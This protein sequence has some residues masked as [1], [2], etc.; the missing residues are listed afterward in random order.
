MG[1]DGEVL[2]QLATW[3][4]EAMYMLDSLREKKEKQVRKAERELAETHDGKCYAEWER[5]AAK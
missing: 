2:R 1:A 4:I 3:F 5:K